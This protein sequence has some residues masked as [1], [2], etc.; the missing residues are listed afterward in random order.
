MDEPTTAPPGQRLEADVECPQCEQS[1]AV[2]VPDGEA[3]PTVS[4]YVLAFGEHR[5][6]RCPAGHEFWVYYC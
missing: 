1:V 4:P 3:E 6:V 2:S 5:R